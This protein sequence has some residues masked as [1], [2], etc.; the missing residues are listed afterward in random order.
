MH[1]HERSEKSRSRFFPLP[2]LLVGLCAASACGNDGSEP[3][4]S[5]GPFRLS[6]H[7]DATFGAPHGGQ[8]IEIAVI[9]VSNGTTVARTSGVIS[10][11][12][13]PSFALETGAILQEGESYHVRY[14]IDS[15]FGGGTVGVCDPPAVDHQW[16]TEFLSVANDIDFIASHQPALIEDVCDSF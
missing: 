5:D 7:L 12:Q 8:P 2:V 16:S 14:W 3:T 11:T 4:G 1:T 6:Y 15:N 10:A 9:R 13:D